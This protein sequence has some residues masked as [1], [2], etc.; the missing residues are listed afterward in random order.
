MAMSKEEQKA[1][2][3]RIVAKSPMTEGERKTYEL[4]TKRPED[5][6]APGETRVCGVCGQEFRDEV[7]QKGNVIV[8]ALEKFSDHQ[9]FHN[10]SPEQ[11]A[12]AHERIQAGKE[13]AKG[14]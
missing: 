13:A 10:P 12:T 4:L 5:Y 8:P 7:D 14:Q 1:A 2:A 6:R 11:W 9:A 3:A